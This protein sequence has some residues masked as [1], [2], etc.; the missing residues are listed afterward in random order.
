MA[1]SGV[2]NDFIM[3]RQLPRRAPAGGYHEEVVS[4]I[5][6]A[7]REVGDQPAVGRPCRVDL[8]AGTLDQPPWITA[9]R[10][11][12]IQIPIVGDIGRVDERPAVRSPMKRADLTDGEHI[13][14]RELRA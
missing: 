10:R 12:D 1:G 9:A 2:V 13:V 7:V 5:A 14:Q 3:E 11:H 6:I 8:V 4:Q